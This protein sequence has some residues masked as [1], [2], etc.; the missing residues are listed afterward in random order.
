MDDPELT[1]EQQQMVDAF[2]SEDV[3]AIDVALLAA[4]SQ[5]WRKVAFVVVNALRS[6]DSRFP[7][8]PDVYLSQRVRVLVRTGMLSSQGNMLSM[9][10]SEVRLPASARNE[11]E[12]DRPLRDEKPEGRVDD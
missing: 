2:T 9:R 10:F 1:P 3:E 11:A 7:D 8:L 5:Q 12:E 4:S 6:L